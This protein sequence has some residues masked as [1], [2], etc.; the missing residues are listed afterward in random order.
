MGIFRKLLKHLVKK[1][2]EKLDKRSETVEKVEDDNWHLLCKM[3][4]FLSK[5]EKAVNEYLQ[6][7]RLVYIC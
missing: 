4:P 3:H 5:Y 6:D 1:D 2:S 7:F